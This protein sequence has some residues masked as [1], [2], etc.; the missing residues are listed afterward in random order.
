MRFYRIA[1][2]DR[3]PTAPLAFS[4]EGAAKF[5]GRWNKRGVRAVYCSDTLSGACLETLVHLRPIPRVF[6]ESVYY[7]IEFAESLLERPELSKLPSSW[8]SEMVS[9]ETREFGTLFLKAGR[10]VGLVVPSS[11]ISLGLNAVI[12]PLHR[13]FSLSGV[14][15]PTPFSYD[16]RLE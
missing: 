5:P 8:N 12:N 15:G 6:P 14:K 10:A 2:V 7:E 4:G 9:E 11:V 16:R 3:A 13:S 1:R